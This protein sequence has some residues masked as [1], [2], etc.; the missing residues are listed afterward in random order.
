MLDK[1]DRPDASL[2]IKT[3]IGLRWATDTRPNLKPMN[4]AEILR[5]PGLGRNRCNLMRSLIV[6]QWTPTVQPTI[7]CMKLT[8]FQLFSDRWTAVLSYQVSKPGAT[9]V[10][11]RR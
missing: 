7:K 6:V 2:N 1:M 11:L 10:P 4:R 9:N 8:V 3:C 5:R